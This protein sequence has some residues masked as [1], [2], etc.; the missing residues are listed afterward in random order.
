MLLQAIARAITRLAGFVVE[1][2]MR[3]Y[4]G[5]WKQRDAND[6]STFY[7]RPIGPAVFIGCADS[8]REFPREGTKKSNE[9]PASGRQGRADTATSP[10]DSCLPASFVRSA[11]SSDV[12]EKNQA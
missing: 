2:V 12:C 1:N 6:R 7:I 5:R 8:A 11:V 4:T 9:T 10:E 3:D